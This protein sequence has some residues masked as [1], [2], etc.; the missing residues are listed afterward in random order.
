LDCSK[1]GSDNKADALFCKKCGTDLRGCKNVINR[2]NGQINLLAVFIGLIFSVIIL[3]I[4][5]LLF[6]GVITSGFNISIYVGIVLLAMA[7]F[8]SIVTGILG[9]NNI[10]EGYVNGVFLSLFILVF[11][12]FVLGIILFVFM[13]IAT[14][15]ASAFGSFSTVASV[16]T[17]TSSTGFLYNWIN[18][19]ETIGLVIMLFL[20]GGLGAALGVFIKNSL[21]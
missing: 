3:F 5:A 16:P 14:T 8:G 12:G 18:L 21:K 19:I 17:T 6:G 20:L 4:G 15:L 1:C 7:F 10:N 13:G 11:L 9:G 2:M